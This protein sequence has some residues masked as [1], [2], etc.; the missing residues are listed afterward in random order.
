MTYFAEILSMDLR[1]SMMQAKILIAGSVAST[2]AV[3][4]YAVKF[5][6]DSDKMLEYGVMLVVII[7]C[8]LMVIAILMPGSIA[9]DGSAGH[10]IVMLGV[11]PGVAFF[12]GLLIGGVVT[13][14]AEDWDHYWR[15]SIAGTL[16]ARWASV[17]ASSLSPQ[18]KQ[19]GEHC[20][21][22]NFSLGMIGDDKSGWT[23]L[24]Y[25]AAGN[26]VEVA[27]FLL[28]ARRPSLRYLSRKR[29]VNANTKHM[30]YGSETVIRVLSKIRSSG[31]RRYLSPYPDYIDHDTIVHNVTS[32][33]PLH[34]AAGFGS[35]EV[36]RLLL[37]NS[38]DIAAK[39]SGGYT[40]LHYA[41]LNKADKVTAL[42]LKA[43]ADIEAKDTHDSTPLHAAAKAYSPLHA[44]ME[45]GPD[46]EV[47]PRED[48]LF[49]NVKI[50]GNGKVAALLL[51]AGA[52]VDAQNAEGYTPLHYAAHYNAS[53]VAALLLKAG[54]DIE[55]KDAR[56]YTPLHGA[57]HYNAGNSAALLLKAGADIEAG[58]ITSSFTPLRSAM[59]KNADWVAALLLKAGADIAAGDGDHGTLLHSATNDN[60][61]KVAAVLLKA[62]ADI[63]AKDVNG[64]TP[65]H[66][67]AYHNADKVATVLL[68]NG[69]NKNARN[70]NNETPLDAAK[71]RRK[72]EIIHLLENWPNS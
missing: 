62:G 53:N 64:N 63:E 17:A 66:Y 40:P 1:I 59:W 2:L 28:D 45:Q 24:H 55:A 69:A 31:L 33:T 72:P 39:D 58:S 22:R 26:W 65:L 56:G 67:A 70:D 38:A 57:A 49:F 25:A 41:V 23:D 61:D 11:I 12:G 8:V 27:Q 37:K 16:D 10:F 18:S 71:S 7:D 52:D 47:V 19:L 13:F 14:L 3:A 30:E 34:I 20:L 50:D 43:G 44:A 4:V 46:V 15:D 42:L 6:Y 60:S 21:G 36:S 48:G 5:N 9:D 54:A 35:C 29:Y 32:V 51:K 68:E